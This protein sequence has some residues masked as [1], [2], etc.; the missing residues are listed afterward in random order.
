MFTFGTYPW[1]FNFK[2]PVLI[3]Y[4]NSGAETRRQLELKY[5]LGTVF[6]P[7]RVS[8]YSMIC[9]VCNTTNQHS[10]HSTGTATVY[11]MDATRSSCFSCKVLA[12]EIIPYNGYHISC[13]PV[14]TDCNESLMHAR[15]LYCR[16][17]FAWRTLQLSFIH[18]F[19][20]GKILANFLCILYKIAARSGMTLSP[21]LMI[22]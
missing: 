5:I 1:A 9:L 2:R 14:L 22:T 11:Y 10:V 13:I 16:K 15:S 18:C 21:M 8:I 17:K 7:I 19:F 6:R 3:Q 4:L 20:M 12:R